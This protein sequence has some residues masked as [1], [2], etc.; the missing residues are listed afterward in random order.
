MRTVPQGQQL[1]TAR[2]CVWL[3]Q[4]PRPCCRPG[5]SLRP[6]DPDP[7][8]LRCCWLP[9]AASSL[10]SHGRE[11]SRAGVLGTPPRGP[12]STVV[13]VSVR[14]RGQGEFR[15]VI[16]GPGAPWRSCRGPNCFSW[17]LGCWSETRGIGGQRGS[18]RRSGLLKESRGPCPLQRG[19]GTGQRVPKMRPDGGR[20]H[21]ASVAR[22]G[23]VR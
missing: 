10:A 14:S 23:R 2:L 18:P 22:A 17:T 20:T 5:L 6:W 11:E 16:Q 1:C 21:G 8:F 15:V 3:K 4:T 7:S 13:P 19:R 9:L 12:C